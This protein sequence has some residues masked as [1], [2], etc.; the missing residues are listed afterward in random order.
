[1]TTIKETHV[2]NS[3]PAVSLRYC[4]SGPLV[5][6][7]HGIGGNAT[8]WDRQLAVLA[9][10][11][12]AVAWDMRGYG[13]SEDYAGP[14]LLDDLCDD[15]ASVL[16]HFE[17]SKAHIAGLSMGGM[18]AQE[19]YRRSPNRV[20][21]LL[22][23]NT[24][25]G[26]G[27]A[28]TNQQKTEFVQLRRQPLLEGKKPR[29]LLPSMLEVLLGPNPPSSAIENIS[30]SILGLRKESY[31]K[32]IEAIVDF[33]SSDITTDIAVPVLLVSSTCDRVIPLDF[34]ELMNDSLPDSEL[35]VFQQ[36]GHLTNLE[37]PE[38]FNELML[39]F[40]AQN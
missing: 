23:A 8:N 27:A 21:T 14:L 11:Y 10:E 35:F 36:V 28:F 40:L 39:D 3:S 29:D 33:D 24:N 19:F 31:I 12:T 18:I 20:S 26:F 37:R 22:L 5:V 16:D 25:V 9:S 1:M 30:A 6:F 32:A 2:L 7:L 34:M 15:L 4:G 38:E 17:S 13:R